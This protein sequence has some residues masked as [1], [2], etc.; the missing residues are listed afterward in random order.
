MLEP[1]SVVPACTRCLSPAVKRDGGSSPGRRRLRCRTC[2]RTFTEHMGTPFA[3]YRWPREVIAMAVR[4]YGRFRLS[5]ADVRDLLAER[6]T[7]VSARTIL[8]WVHT[9]GPLL[10]AEARRHAPPLGRCWYV[11]ETYVRVSGRWMYLYRAVDEHEQMVDVLLREQRDLAS[12]CAFFVQAIARRGVR[13]TLVVT[14]KPPA[15]RRAIRRHAPGAR[16]VRTGLHRARGET[17]KA[18]E[19]AH[20]PTRDRLRNSRGLKRTDTGQ[21]FLDG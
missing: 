16:H 18:I 8:A 6:G 14:D 12:A 2:R 15:Y 1:R 13:P 5:A 7:D 3:G 11:D 17:T 9:F 19:R 21:R 4:W 10:A 20:V